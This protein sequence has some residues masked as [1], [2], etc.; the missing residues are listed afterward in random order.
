MS[1]CLYNMSAS[2]CVDFGLCWP[3]LVL[4][5]LPAES[6]H[7]R[8]VLQTVS[9][10]EAVVLRSFGPDGGQLLFTRDSGQVMLTRHGTRILTAL[11]LEH[12][13]A[14]YRLARTHTHPHPRHASIW[15]HTSTPII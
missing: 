12:P 2:V 11:R 7:L 14:R 3:L 5:M 9:A 13:L 10:L 15:L 8:H 4:E 6:L 1:I